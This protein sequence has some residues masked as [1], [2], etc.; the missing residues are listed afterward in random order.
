MNF[1]EIV[2]H[3]QQIKAPDLNIE[4]KINNESE[5]NDFILKLVKQDQKDKKF[6]KG[7]MT[8]FMAYLIFAFLIFVINPDPDLN[9]YMRI[10]GS[11]LVL[12]V[13]IF[14]IYL[15]K[16]Y[17]KFSKIS[18][19]TKT[20]EFLSSTKKRLQFGGLNYLILIPFLLLIDIGECF[21]FIDRYWNPDNGIIKGII[22]VNVIYFS[23]LGIGYFF[24][25]R[26]WK[27]DKKALYLQFQELSK[28]LVNNNGNVV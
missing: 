14:T 13:L 11:C 1:E 24:A 10:G 25:K 6:V 12:S 21:I 28:D 2:K 5:M 4:T 7:T 20:K 22:L 18:Y 26:S 16:N 27:K 3:A 17:R 15:R 19:N 8:F 23:L 9:I